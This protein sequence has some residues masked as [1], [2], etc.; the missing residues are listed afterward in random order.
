LIRATKL[1]AISASKTLFYQLG[2]SA[3]MLAVL[4]VAMGEPGVTRLTPIVIASL[5]YQAVIIAFLSFLIWF[6]LLRHYLAA[7]LSVFSFLTPLFGVAA[8]CPARIRLS[9]SR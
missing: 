3:V 7:R 2:V 9:C 8:G 4:A 6:W 1:S 5:F